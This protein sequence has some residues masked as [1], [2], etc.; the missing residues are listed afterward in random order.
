MLIKMEKTKII[1][2]LTAIIALV[3]VT[4]GFTFAQNIGG[5]HFFG[6][7]MGHNNY[8]EGEDWWTNMREHMG[9]EWTGIEDEE[10]FDD[11]TTYMEEHIADL[12]SQ[13][14]YDSMVEYMEEHGYGN[15]MGFGFGGCR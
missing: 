3:T 14:W 1:I 5:N 13:E 12:E 7:M 9:E 8:S 2:V 11:M 10:W 6:G 4:I 15:H